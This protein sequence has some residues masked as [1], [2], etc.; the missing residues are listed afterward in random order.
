MVTTRADVRNSQAAAHA[1][2]G[3]ARQDSRDHRAQCRYERALLRVE[4]AELRS[5]APGML[6]RMGHAISDLAHRNRHAVVAE[7]VGTSAVAGTLVATGAAGSLISGAGSLAAGVTLPAGVTTAAAATGTA[8]TATL[9]PVI[10]P[11]LVTA[12]VTA[13]TI[14]G[15]KAA[16]DAG[17]LAIARHVV[18]SYERE[19][20]PGTREQFSHIRPTVTPSI[21]SDGRSRGGRGDD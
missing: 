16:W 3:Q 20:G 7:V 8:V 5:G 21:P 17:S 14:I 2:L 4:R 1:H 18:N 13:A 12:G 11:V 10:V 6:G 9:A 15:G 19:H